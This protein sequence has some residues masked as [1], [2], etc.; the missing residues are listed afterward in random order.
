MEEKERSNYGLIS[1]LSSA[2]CLVNS[3]L[4]FLN[5]NIDK[6]GI[7]ILYGKI[8]L[9]VALWLLCIVNFICF[10]AK[11]MLKSQQKAIAILLLII[12]AFL[13]LLQISSFADCC[14]DLAG[15]TKSIVTNEY[16]VVWDEI[17]LSSSN[18]EE[19]AYVSDD[20]AKLLNENKVLTVTSNYE[21]ERENYVEVVYYPRT[22][23]LISLEIVQQN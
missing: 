15:G 2:I 16:P 7:K 22:H 14:A 21:V 11:K 23:I 4:I 3:M 19:Y 10:F 17:F 6:I 18:K 20:I 8:G 5:N 12:S 13:A 9:I 1:L